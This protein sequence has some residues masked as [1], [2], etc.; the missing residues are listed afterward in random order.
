MRRIESERVDW[1]IIYMI[2]FNIDNQIYLSPKLKVKIEYKICR[3]KNLFL[4]SSEM[5]AQDPILK[6][7]FRE[8]LNRS[9]NNNKPFQQAIHFLEKVETRVNE[10]FPPPIITRWEIFETVIR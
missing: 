2:W 8:K 9:M 10:K 3:S 4:I 6:T 1:I 7:T 5:F